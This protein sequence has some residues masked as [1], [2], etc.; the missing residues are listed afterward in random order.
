[1]KKILICIVFMSF[2]ITLSI[3]P[4]MAIEYEDYGEEYEKMLDGI[5]Y[6]IAELLP[7]GLF[8]D[9][10]DE[11]YDAVDE[12]SGF[13]Y[14]ISVIGELLGIRGSSALKLFALLLGILVISTL[15]RR[16][17]ELISSRELASALSMCSIGGIMSAVTAVQYEQLLGVSQFLDELNILAT[18]TLPVMGTLYAAGGNI[19]AAAVNNSAMLL[20]TARCCFFL[21]YAKT[22]VTEPLCR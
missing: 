13:S 15:L 3:F 18:A 5:P 17:G 10:A 6:E 14:F 21:Q 22:S 19:G 7:E 20:T 9:N 12:M 1:M 11:I 8:S 16:F 2:M 4:S